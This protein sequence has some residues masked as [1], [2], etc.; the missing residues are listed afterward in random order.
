MSSSNNNIDPDKGNPDKSNEII[1]LLTEDIQAHRDYIHRLYRSAFTVGAVLVALGVGLGT[2]ILGKQLDAKV[3]EYRIVDAL[4]KSAE[5]IA[6]ELMKD[7]KD[8]VKKEIEEHVTE[9]IAR[10]TEDQIEK[11][12]EKLNEKS[13]L[14]LLESF[15]FP[16]GT[17]VAVDR[18]ECPQGWREYK[19]AY[20]RFIRGIDKSGSNIDPDGRRRPGQ[21]QEDQFQTH[22]HDI[23]PILYSGGSNGT[24][25][26]SAQ[27]GNRKESYKILNPNGRN[28]EETRPKNVALLYCIK[29]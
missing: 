16:L 22:Q 7:A 25:Y 20:G 14:Q 18:E 3:F 24:I 11:R 5:M 27:S 12:L 1:K 26:G 21:F 8:H 29:E 6:N 2:W 9:S 13:P 4:R 23:S 15:S 10:Q 28:G 17:V 19:E